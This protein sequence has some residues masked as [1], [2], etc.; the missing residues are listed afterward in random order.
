MDGGGTTATSL[1]G[2]MD[3]AVRRS[4]HTKRAAEQAERRGFHTSKLPDGE[5]LGTLDCLALKSSATAGLLLS[6]NSGVM[7]R[8]LNRVAWLYGKTLRKIQYE[9][10]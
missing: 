9:A 4:G 7:L 2:G 6:D 8:S 3:G 5:R 1:L 10:L